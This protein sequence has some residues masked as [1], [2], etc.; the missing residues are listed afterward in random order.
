[1]Q[2][3]LNFLGDFVNLLILKINEFDPS[4][5]SVSPKEC[6]F[7]IYKDIRFSKDKTPYKTNIEAYIAND[8]KKQVCRVLRSY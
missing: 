2:T 6:L 1:M 7:R 3:I 4:I 5:G 8:R